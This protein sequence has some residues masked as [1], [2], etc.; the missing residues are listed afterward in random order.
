MQLWAMCGHSQ[1]ARRCADLVPLTS[2]NGTNT[3][4]IRAGFAEL[5]IVCS[6]S[7][8]R[9]LGAGLAGLMQVPRISEAWLC[10]GCGGFKA[11]E[12]RRSNPP[13]NLEAIRKKLK[14]GNNRL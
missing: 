9:L 4:H 6:A 12:G 10:S 8:R 13:A 3:G 11:L 14:A 5:S 1:L 2:I 7:R